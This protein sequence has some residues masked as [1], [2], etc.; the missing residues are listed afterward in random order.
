M[1]ACAKD[2]VEIVRMLLDYKPPPDINI[3]ERLHNKTCIMMAAH[4]NNN[5]ICRQL[6]LNPIQK[7]HLW[8]MSKEGKTIVEYAGKLD[9]DNRL[10]IQTQLHNMIF[11][12]VVPDESIPIDVIRMV[13]EW[14]Y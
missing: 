8:H 1:R 6:L 10:E 2:A 14:T 12:V 3:V 7:C 4:K 9:A 5:A 13:A 11:R